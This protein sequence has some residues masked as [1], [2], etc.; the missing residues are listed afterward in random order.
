[1]TM[2]QS[3]HLV[4]DPPSSGAS[5]LPHFDWVHNSV[6][7]GFPG[8]LLFT[9]CADAN[10]GVGAFL[11]FF[12]YPAAWR[13]THF[14]VQR[15]KGGTG[16]GDVVF[17]RGFVAFQEQAVPFAYR[18]GQPGHRHVAGLALVGLA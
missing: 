10:P 9:V 11:T 2:G 8:D 3:I 13:A 14:N 18:L 4:T 7:G 16:A 15:G 17:P 6:S 5:P 12:L 1:M